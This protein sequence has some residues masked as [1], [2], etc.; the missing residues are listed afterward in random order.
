MLFIT[1]DKIIKSVSND[2]VEIIKNIIELHIPDGE[3]DCDATYSI[4]NFYN[5]TGIIEPKYKFDILPQTEG[6]TKADCRELPLE[7]N[8]I[9]SLIFDPPFIANQPSEKNIKD[10]T[11]GLIS[12]RFGYYKSIPILWDMYKDALKEI[13]RVLNDKGTLIF[14]CQDTVS[15]GKQYLSHVF[16]INEAIKLGF[17]PKDMFVLT[18][19]NRM[20]GLHKQQLHSRKYHSY[21]VVFQK[22]KSKVDYEIN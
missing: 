3:I 4:G 21:F 14:K 8:S 2:Q 5:N 6:V 9:N 18:A 20:I 10:G 12:K 1:Q 11:I 19:K 7:D 17:Y 15:S 16:I 13:Y 22:A